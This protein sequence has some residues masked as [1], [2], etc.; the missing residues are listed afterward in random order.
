MIAGMG[1]ETI[2]SI[3]KAA[4]WTADGHHTLLLQPQ[5]HEELVRQYLAENGFIITRE[6]LVRDRWHFLYIRLWKPE[7]ERRS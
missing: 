2:L 7:P 6:A 1:G 3:L 4:P 5:T